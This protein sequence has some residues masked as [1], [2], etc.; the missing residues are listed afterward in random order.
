MYYKRY[1][2]GAGSGNWGHKGRPG[3]IGGSGKGGNDPERIKYGRRLRQLAEV[4][5]ADNVKIQRRI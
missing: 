2:G 5:G 4:F 3:K 1:N